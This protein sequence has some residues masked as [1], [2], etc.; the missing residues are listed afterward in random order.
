MLTRN[1]QHH[2]MQKND[3]PTNK[4]NIIQENDTHYKFGERS[5]FY[6]SQSLLYIINV[7]HIQYT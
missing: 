4:T 3:E 6:N 1:L 7:T 2:P 5:K